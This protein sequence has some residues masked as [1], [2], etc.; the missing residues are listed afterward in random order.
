MR[1][2]DGGALQ[3]LWMKGPAFARLRLFTN[4]SSTERGTAGLLSGLQPV[5]EFVETLSLQF[6]REAVFFYDELAAEVIGIAWRPN[7]KSARTQP[8]NLT[9]LECKHVAPAEGHLPGRSEGVVW[10]ESQVIAEMVATSLGLVVETISASTS[11]NGESR[12]E[13]NS[14]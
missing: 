10:N 12:G 13:S 5:K 3:E 14:R 6:G 2:L 8:S 11:A 4:L 7:I 9:V 1:S